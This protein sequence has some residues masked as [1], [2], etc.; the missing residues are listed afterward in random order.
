[1]IEIVWEFI[2]KETYRGQFELAFGPGGVWSKLYSRSPGFKGTTVLRDTEKHHRY[3]VIDLWST[4]AQ[5]NRALVEQKTEFEDM[6]TSLAEWTES[7]TEVGKFRVMAEATV[8]PVRKT[9]TGK[10]GGRHRVRR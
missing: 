7:T 2:I 3:L 10:T 4:E 5:R 1:M 8:K 6:R 9:R